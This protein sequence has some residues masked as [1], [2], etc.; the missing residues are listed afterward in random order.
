MC[1]FVAYQGHPVSLAD[2]FYRPRHSLVKQSASA[3]EMSQTFNGD[4]FGTGWYSPEIDPLP[5]VV[6]AAGP[7]WSNENARRISTR[8][9]SR[10]IFGHVRAASPGMPVQDSNCHPFFHG[11]VMFMHN[12][13]IQGFHGFRRR[14]L[15]SLSE[16]AFEAIG[17]STDSEHAF[18]LLLDELGDPAAEISPEDLRQAVTG[19]LRRLVEL[20]HAAGVSTEMHCNFAVTDGSCLV[21]TRFAY[22][23]SRSPASLHYSAG[24]RYVI[25][26]EDGDML[27]TDAAAPGA[28]II[29]SEPLTRRAEKWRDVPPNHSITVDADLGLR[30]DPIEIRGR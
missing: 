17:G 28:V 27:G 21:A 5:C 7:A 9:L 4:G 18:A 16:R 1:R 20:A 24:E 30:L 10:N 23:S 15:Q 3:E 13:S 6:K 29:A 25:D 14:L 26:G 22:G 12:G 11:R 19:T 2:L 8:I